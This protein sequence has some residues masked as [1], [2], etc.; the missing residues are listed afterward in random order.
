MDLCVN[1][2]MYEGKACVGGAL[3]DSAAFDAHVTVRH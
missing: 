2:Q 3:L 1:V